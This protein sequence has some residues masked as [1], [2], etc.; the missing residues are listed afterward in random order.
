MCKRSITSNTSNPVNPPQVRHEPHQK[1][2]TCQNKY[3]ILNV[4][5]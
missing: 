4:N 2:L 3:Q 5:R 1:S